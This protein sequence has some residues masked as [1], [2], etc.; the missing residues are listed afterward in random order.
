MY[1]ELANDIFIADGGVDDFDNLTP[2]EL[3]KIISD[4]LPNYIPDVL[5]AAMHLQQISKEGS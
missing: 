1:S 4:Q 3:V 5:R 2:E